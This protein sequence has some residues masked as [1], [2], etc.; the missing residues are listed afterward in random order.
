[1]VIQGLDL[2]VHTIENQT[3]FRVFSPKLKGKT[4]ITRLEIKKNNLL[5]KRIK[6]GVGFVEEEKN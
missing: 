5:M 2:H 4:E 3:N 1:M 6:T